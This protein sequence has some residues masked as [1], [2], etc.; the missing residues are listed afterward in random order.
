MCV[1][2]NGIPDTNGNVPQNWS[3]NVK[4]EGP[5]VFAKENRYVKIGKVGQSSIRMSFHVYSCPDVEEIFLEKLGRMRGKKR[6]INKYFLKSTLLYNEFDN[7]AGIPGYD[8]LI[9]SEERG[10]DDVQAYC[11][12]VKNRLGAS[13]YHFEII[14]KEDRVINQRK[15]TYF[16]PVCI[17]GA[18]LFGSILVHVGCCLNLIRPRVQIHDNVHEDR[19][20]HTYDEIRTISYGAVSNIRSSDTN[21]TQGHGAHIS[22]ETIVP[23]TDGSSNELNAD[24]HNDD[25]PQREVTDVQGQHR[26][27][28]MIETNIINKEQS[29]DQNSQTSNESE[30]ETSNNVM[31]G[32]VGDGYENPYETVT[33]DRLESHQ[34]IQITRERN[35]SLSSA[36]SNCEEQITEKSLTKEAGYINLQL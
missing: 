4:Y 24:F 27:I 7:K 11:I 3:T 2:S 30:S 20:H 15:R 12:T 23:L 26:P 16:V 10:T 14:K 22:N 17:L 13:D 25:L 19:T 6:K 21:D 8:I 28:S 33:Q 34:Y 32:N 36:E 29:S 5:P 35:T 9:E 18:V 1:V 31:V